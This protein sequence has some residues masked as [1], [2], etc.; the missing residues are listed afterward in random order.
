MN[1]FNLQEYI[2]KHG[3]DNIVFTFIE[4]GTSFR[5]SFNKDKDLDIYDPL[6]EV[7]YK[8]KLKLINN[9]YE[10][11]VPYYMSDLELLI[12]NNVVKISLKE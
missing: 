9:K 3:M 2:A 12:K 10:K 6:K 11:I 7:P 4:E 5:I 1:D 8:I